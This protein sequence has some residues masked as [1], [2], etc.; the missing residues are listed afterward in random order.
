MSGT[1]YVENGVEIDESEERV[2]PCRE[3]WQARLTAVHFFLESLS[4][5]RG[6]PASDGN[7]IKYKKKRPKKK[8]S[9]K[10]RAAAAAYPSVWTVHK[11][12]WTGELHEETERPDRTGILEVGSRGLST[13]R[14]EA[15]SSA[16]SC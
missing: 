13:K 12:V 11:G 8:N 15:E 14:R 2:S 5:Q 3:Q 6:Q 16:D 9:K 4:I 7:K 1:V 10:V